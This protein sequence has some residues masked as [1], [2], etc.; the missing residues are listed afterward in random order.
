M[1]RGPRER[2]MYARSDGETERSYQIPT[3]YVL[4][5]YTV[6]NDPRISQ[7]YIQGKRVVGKDTLSQYV[8]SI[9]GES[10][11]PNVVLP[12]IGSRFLGAN[13]PGVIGGFFKGPAAA[14]PLMLLA[15]HLFSKSEA[16]ALSLF[17]SGDAKADYL[18]GIKASFNY[19]YQPTSDGT[20]QYNAY[21][22]ANTTN[23]LVDWDAT[24][25][26]TPVGTDLST[27]LLATN[28]RR[29]VSKQ[30]KII[31]Q[32]YL[33]LNTVASTEAWDDYRRTAF[34]KLPAASQSSSTRVDKL[35]T[36]LLYP[37]SEIN[38]NAVN[39]P[40]VTQYTKIFW[41]SVD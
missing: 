31:Y 30:E 36:R 2:T 13:S 23:G 33:A 6:N 22:A 20:A 11:P 32:K 15:E 14:T 12:L 25:T 3:Q 1:E 37:Q 26:S 7:L 16:E 27:T 24:T 41:D 9:P 19:Y 21:I 34:P 35:P 8:G 29:A 38:T 28:A 4:N 18:A 5:Q 17:P 40:S 10:N 39:I